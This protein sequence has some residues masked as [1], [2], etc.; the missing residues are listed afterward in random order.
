MRGVNEGVPVNGACKGR[1]RACIAHPARQQR[2]VMHN[3]SVQD[4]IVMEKPSHSH[5]EL[6]LKGH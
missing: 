3:P 2:G 6:V 1:N 4:S 5:E